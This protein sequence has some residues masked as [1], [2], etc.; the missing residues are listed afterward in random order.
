MTLIRG[1]CSL[2]TVFFYKNF[3][4]ATRFR[5]NVFMHGFSL[6]KPVHDTFFVIGIFLRH[7]VSMDEIVFLGEEM[8]PL[9][10]KCYHEM[11][12]SSISLG[13]NAICHEGR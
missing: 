10:K 9:I 5:K 3:P 8:L 4:P 11:L 12:S 13:R 6:G 1:L 2:Y 7:F